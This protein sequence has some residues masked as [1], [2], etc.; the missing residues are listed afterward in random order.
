[1]TS[2]RASVRRDWALTSQAF[3]G[4]LA[5]LDPDAERAGE[6]Y[7][8]LRRRLVAF[9]EWRGS[10]WP[11]THADET[12]SRVIRRLDEGELVVNV[13][14]YA[15]GVARMVLL[16]ALRRQE[17]E[18]RSLAAARVTPASPALAETDPRWACLEACLARL[19]E[20]DRR[21]ILDYYRDEGR[22][23]DV[24]KALADRLG[25]AAPVLRARVF[26]IRERLHDCARACLRDEGE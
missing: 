8:S 14:A 19:P 21:L 3:H 22:R 24:R 25:I 17:L 5:R 16:E 9:F 4:F 11:E 13:E 20:E 26:R 2:G 18:R 10:W 7:E 12:I 1:M 23:S 6:R 15:T